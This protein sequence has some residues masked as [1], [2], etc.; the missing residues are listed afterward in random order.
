MP[1]PTLKL[2]HWP[3]YL[4]VLLVMVC[5]L[6]AALGPFGGGFWWALARYAGTTVAGLALWGGIMVLVSRPWSA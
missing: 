5:P 1:I 3:K 4:F 6:V 2:A